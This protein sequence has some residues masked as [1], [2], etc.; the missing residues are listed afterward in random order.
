L[1]VYLIL[2]RT[3]GATCTCTQSCKD[4]QVEGRITFRHILECAMGNLYMLVCYKVTLCACVHLCVCVCAGVSAC[5]CVC[6]WV[7]VCAC[8]RVC[9]C[10]C[11][12]V[13]AGARVRVRV[14]VLVRV[15]VRLVQVLAA[16]LRL[17]KKKAKAPRDQASASS[18]TS[19]SSQILPPSGGTHSEFARARDSNRP[20][21][22]EGGGGSE[23]VC[24]CV[25]LCTS[26]VFA[27]TR[28]MSTRACA[29]A[30][31]LSCMRESVMLESA[32]AF[33]RSDIT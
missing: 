19:S 3:Q 13:C 10:A 20:G 4:R 9:V 11:V 25:N 31:A 8:V 2:E 32:F 27:C 7:H 30:R 12:R 23:I 29:C 24:A 26:C 1:V 28:Q 22:D 5:A 16:A 6:V 21:E 18:S 33:I 14:R 15:R 17:T